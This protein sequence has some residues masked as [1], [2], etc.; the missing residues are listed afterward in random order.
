MPCALCKCDGHNRST[1]LR[2]LDTKIQD[3][4]KQL[5]A[6]ELEKTEILSERKR[7]SELKQKLDKEAEAKAAAKLQ[8]QANKGTGDAREC[9]SV[10][11]RAIGDAIEHQYEFVH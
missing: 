7:R 9:E 1:C 6:L 2:K 11:S 4:E 3:I 5:Q 10:Q 8:R